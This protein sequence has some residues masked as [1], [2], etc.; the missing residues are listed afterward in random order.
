M[1][2]PQSI[3]ADD[4]R[5]AVSRTGWLSVL[6]ALAGDALGPALKRPGRHVA[7]PVHGG[8]HGDGFRLFADV[9]RSGG[10]ICATCGAYP[11]GLAL[12]RWLFHWSFP[13]ALAQV[14]S[15]LG[16]GSG[17]SGTATPVRLR[18]APSFPR[19]IP[20]KGG[21][22]QVRLALRRSWSPSLAPQDPRAAPLR[23]YLASR[24]L[25]AALLDPRVVRFH[26]GLGYWVRDANDRP[27]CVGR[28]PAML[29]VVADRD[30]R[31]ISIHRTYVR[32]DGT[33]KAP[34]PSPRKLM[35]H[36]G[37]T[38]LSGA[39]IRLCPAASDL[40]I[41]EG[42]ETALAVRAI[43]G[44]P[45][46]ACVSATLLRGFEV[47]SG[48]ERLIVWADKDRSGAGEA[49]AAVLQARLADVVDV[50]VRL[51]EAPIPATARGIDWADVWLRQRP[52]GHVGSATA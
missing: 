16:L 7:C 13:E 28:F 46:W 44:M 15:V 51:P 3:E 52:L 34:V 24:G 5:R 2:S 40:G 8:R 42:I 25:D 22:A 32:A 41:A 43:T 39:A 49:A 38:P 18:V 45:V 48:V 23:R 30:G 6:S 4:V 9:D 14:A 26:P 50:Q 17:P 35:A 12:L 29:A 1:Q 36:A 47:P 21:P 27:R 10:G 31:P 33:G 37:P 11:D 20:E 19:S